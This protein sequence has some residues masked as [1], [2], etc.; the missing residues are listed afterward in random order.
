MAR[1]R[2][3]ENIFDPP[4]SNTTFSEGHK[5]KGILDDYAERQVINT[6]EFAGNCV[7]VHGGMCFG[8]IH[9]A[10]NTDADTIATATIS[11]FERFTTNNPSNNTIP[12]FNNNQIEITKAGNYFISVS[13]S[14]SG[15]ASVDWHFH[16]RIN[17]TTLEN[18]HTNRK[19]GAGGDIGSASMS[20][21][22]TLSVGDMLNVSMQ[23][24]AGVN[25]SITM[26]DCTLSLF[27]IGGA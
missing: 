12:D 21:I 19:L 11:K 9:V 14:F 5:S 27:Q 8:G 10:D 3:M 22:A 2:R 17:T 13:F 7:F 6:K 4:K 16:V 24:T 23:H 18:L 20:G 25:K 26:E 1:Q 15:D